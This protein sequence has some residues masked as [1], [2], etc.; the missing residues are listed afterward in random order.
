VSKVSSALYGGAAPVAAEAAAPGDF[1]CTRIGDDLLMRWPQH[2]LSLAFSHLREGSDGIQSEVIAHSAIA[3]ELHW[4]RLNLVSTAAREGLVKKLDRAHPTA[5]W[6]SIL[7]RACRLAA[8]ELRA[9]EPVVALLPSRATE[10]RHLLSKLALAGETNVLFGDGG[11]GKS[12]F[13]LA[14][15]VAVGAGAALPAGITATAHTPV[16]YLDWESSLEEHQD[17]LAGLLDGLGVSVAPP[18]LYRP[19]SRALADDAAF[20]RAEISRHG[21]GFVIVDSLAPACGA[22]PEGA[23]AAIRAM[24]AMRSFGAAV[25]RLV[26][27]HVSKAGA[28]QRSGPAKPFGSVFVQNL[29]R[30]VWEIRKAEDDGGDDLV[31]GFYHRKVNRGRLFP[32]FGLRLEFRGASTVLNGHDVGQQPDLM[33]RASLAFRIQKTLAGGARSVPDLMDETGKSKDT[34]TRTL[35][36]LRGSGKVIDLADAKWGLKA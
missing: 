30:S 25:T 7:E 34:I 21:V 20:L 31:L 1:E 32:P 23:D 28:E 16:L 24:N 17:R 27:A 33:A 6:R 22:E 3:G 29:A 12:L 11:S 19:M 18:I 26:I 2:A 10:T 9:G 13:A 35:R 15:A 14:L 36:R 4:G 8:Q 5:P